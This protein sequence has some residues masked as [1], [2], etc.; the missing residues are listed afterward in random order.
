MKKAFLLPC[1][2]LAGLS[3]NAQTQHFNPFKKSTSDQHRLFV[4]KLIQ[5]QM[6]AGSE[7]QKPTGTQQRVV[8]QTFIDAADLATDSF[9]YK[10]SGTRGSKYNQNNANFDYNEEFLSDYL[11][12]S[13]FQ[14][15]YTSLDL[16]ADSIKYYS[17][18]TLS[19]VSSGFYRSDNKLDSFF[20]F[21]GP[22]VDTGVSKIR[23]SFNSQGFLNTAIS[24]DNYN[25]PMA[26]TQ[27]QIFSYNTAQT[28]LLSDTLFNS[29]G[30][31]GLTF[32]GVA[33]YHYNAQNNVDTVKYFNV[34]GSGLQLSQFI[35]ILY[36]ADNKVQNVYYSLYSPDTL[37][38]MDTFVYSN[39][40]SYYT[41]WFI[42]YYF[43]SD[44]TYSSN[45]INKYV[46][47]NGLPDSVVSV[48][49]GDID[50]ILKYHY[51]SYNNPDSIIG[52]NGDSTLAEKLNF[53]YEIYDDGIS[54]IKNV[55]NSNDF[56]IYP[57]P[58]DNKINIDWKTKQAN[59][60]TVNLVNVL[61]QTVYSKIQTL[62]TGNN[63]LD[64]PKLNSGNYII[65]INDASGNTWSRQL[66]K[67]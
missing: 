30:V 66:V 16:L 42:T 15:N 37:V 44:S 35:N 26:T 36:T 14:M 65:L 10:Y 31:G 48:T 20:V 25:G 58:F 5:K 41:N 29:D 53:Y 40:Q 45:A 8:A 38:I 46:G 28:H 43:P 7:A 61:G 49:D 32:A 60:A 24:S 22:L 67:K 51:N 11:P 56:N 3:L 39:N 6:Q 18:D 27:K 63:V 12:L 19:S 55:N 1:I 23:H 9:T 34:G 47:T 50:F 33:T 17:N 54:S 21:D 52:L 64:L 57:N 62:N 4:N 13:N 59:E 2:L